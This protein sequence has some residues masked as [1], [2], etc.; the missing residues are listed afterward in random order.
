MKLGKWAGIAAAAA[1][2]FF[3][4][5]V[6]PFA[7]WLREF[8]SW[9][10]AQGPAAFPIY[11]AAY[12]VVTVTLM[13]AWAMTIMAGF[14][15]GLVPGVAVVWVGSVCG[16]AVSFLIARH[17]AR[18]RVA[19]HAAGSPR[20]AVIDRVIGEKGWKIV[21][22]LRLS[23]LVPVTFSNYFYGLTAVRFWPYLLA[24]AVG[25]LPVTVLYASLGVTG[26]GVAPLSGGLRTSGWTWA[27]IGVGVFFTLAGAITIARASREALEKDS[28]K[29]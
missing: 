24:T 23:P 21:L 15:F 6:L 22:L 28:L 11:A 18:G 20:Y 29:G 9:V 2:L 1:L 16:A 7:A 14:L 10:S 25:I 4:G 3:A 27:A 17:L 12:V 26:Q 13:P 5:R 8:S 19:R